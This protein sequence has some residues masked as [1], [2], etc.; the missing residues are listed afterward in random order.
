TDYGL[1]ALMRSQ[2][3]SLLMPVHN[4]V[5]LL[6][7]VLESLAENTTYSDLELL[8]VDDHSTDG[9]LDVL[10]RWEASGRLPAVRGMGNSGG[11][12][13]CGGARAA[14]PSSGLARSAP[15]SAVS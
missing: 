4:R 10:R 3:V 15:A 13:R 12:G 8:T 9:S 5:H 2:R 11:G 6:D 14:R 7:R 1:C